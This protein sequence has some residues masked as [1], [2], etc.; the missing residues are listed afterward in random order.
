MSR[1]KLHWVGKF[2]RIV[3]PKV[4]HLGDITRIRSK[5]AGL[6]TSVA[7]S[8]VRSLLA[9]SPT[10]LAEALFSIWAGGFR[11]GLVIQLRLL[12]TL[13]H[14]NAVTFVVQAGNVRLQMKQQHGR[15]ADGENKAQCCTIRKSWFVHR[16]DLIEV[17]DFQF[18]FS[19]RRKFWPRIR[20]QEAARRENSSLA[21]RVL[22]CN[23]YYRD[24]E[25]QPRRLW[26]QG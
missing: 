8:R 14:G 4:C 1:R 11:Y 24:I 18:T 3:V 26:R 23:R 6:G 5:T 2:V 7:R 10:G 13:P 19:P 25:N 9:G 16:V 15:R 20:F 22:R 21:E 12:S 17:P